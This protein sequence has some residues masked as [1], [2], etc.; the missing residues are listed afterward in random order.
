MLQ[1]PQRSGTTAPTPEA[2]LRAR[3]AELEAELALA[4]ASQFSDRAAQAVIRASEP[5]GTLPLEA[6]SDASLLMSRRAFIDC[7]QRAAEMFGC[8]RETIVGRSFAEF[9]PEVQPDGRPSPAKV[10][11]R[12]EAAF[13]GAPQSFEWRHRR[14]DG[15][16]FEAE[17][18]LNRIAHGT[19]I[20]LQVIV[21]DRTRRKVTETAL[22]ESE[23]RYRLL[24]EHSTDLISRH[25]LDAR[26]LYASPACRELLGYE[27]QDLIDMSFIDLAHPD[28]RDVVAASHR[29][30]VAARAAS[31]VT[32]RARRKAGDHVWVETT[33]RAVCPPG[34]GAPVE[35]V[36]DT[37]D[38]TEPRRVQEALHLSEA[39][40]RAVVTSLPVIVF[41]LDR[42][43]VF[44]LSE[45]RGLAGL[46]QRPGEVV[47]RSVFDVY[48]DVPALC[49]SVRRAL[50]GEA[51]SSIATLGQ[52]VFAVSYSP[53][54]DDRGTVQGV[55]GAAADITDRERSEAARLKLER[56][57]LHAQKLEGLGVLAGGIA[58]DFNNL[59]MAVLGN[60]DLA[61]E[62][63]SPASPARAGI[64][65]AVRAS[66]RAADLT[67]QMLA[68]AGEGHCVVQDLDLSRLVEENAH[69]LKAA[70]SKNVALSPR[71]EPR[72]PPIQADAGQIQQVVMNLLTNAS[73]AM[74]ERGGTVTLTTGAQVCNARCL[75]RSR[76][77][78]KPEPGLFA[79]LAVSDTGCGMD[80]RT[81]ARLFDPFF[82]T[83]FKGRGLG[84]SA[85]LGIVRGH[86]GAIIVE[87]EPALGTTIVVMFPAT[88]APCRSSCDAPSFPA[89]AARRAQQAPAGTILVV[90][91]EEQ[92]RSLCV[93]MLRRAGYQTAAA[94]DGEEALAVF[95]GR[96]DEFACVLLDLTMPRL[97]GIATYEAMRSIREDVKVI[98]CTGYDEQAV[99]GFGRRGLAG[100]I[101]KPYDIQQLEDELARV[102]DSDAGGVPAET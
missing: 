73:E 94:A 25:A 86:G 56:R 58:H 45:G 14:L 24:A 100:F 1:M 96:P 54:F 102:L 37:R 10:Q 92:V 12:V 42:S 22:R 6:T 50:L 13:A 5:E 19:E 4:R 65:N 7:N 34:G 35:I 40:L 67:R 89:V 27:P 46:G 20:S 39:R 88:V 81:K 83:K 66:R 47:G 49:D 82:T 41:S 32:W 60:L 85:V 18:H 30:V 76:L 11:E 69:I 80:D 15:T 38:V 87:S 64:E 28:D 63:L 16:L 3:V 2:D 79:W 51:V 99:E 93:A 101:Q 17:V 97:D 26:F 68:Y 70:I 72:M 77:E 74:G 31:T 57:L 90:D 48:R 59:L 78:E 53:V 98:L 75:S 62:D 71:L 33:T 23:A 91:D 84:M 36:A 8:P 55:I 9:S 52:A 21:R 95:R 61:L 44:T 29:G 43:G